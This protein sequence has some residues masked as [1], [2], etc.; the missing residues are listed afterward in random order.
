MRSGA[1]LLP[2]LLLTLSASPSAAQSVGTPVLTPTVTARY[3][4]DR[5]AFTEGLQYL[6]AAR[7][8]KAPASRGSP[9]C[10]AWT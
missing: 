8:W 5:A 9:A 3:P 2:Y 1:L 7:C 4:H 10:A 6:G